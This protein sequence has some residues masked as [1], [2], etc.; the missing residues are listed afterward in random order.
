ME[1]LKFFKECLEKQ[2]AAKVT[3]YQIDKANEQFVARGEGFTV[4]MPVSEL[5]VAKKGMEEEIWEN[6]LVGKHLGEEL[7]VFVTEIDEKNGLVKCGR[8]DIKLE[9]RKEEKKKINEAIEKGET[10]TVTGRVV[11]IYG[12]GSRGRA[13]LVTE[14]GIRLLLFSRRWSFDYIEDLNDVVKV[15]DEVEVAVYG[16]NDTNNAVDYLVSRMDLLPNPWIGIEEI[17][18][19]GDVVIAKIL[20]RRRGVFNAR[21]EGLEGIVALATFPDDRRLRIAFGGRYQCKVERVYESSHTLVVKPF[22]EKR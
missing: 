14:T 16:H 19:E 15:G 10:Y 11:G 4:V 3:F 13:I 9:K 7:E 21:I 22:A 5:V 18:H 12:E 6:G 20:S 1:D 17:I 2:S 8:V